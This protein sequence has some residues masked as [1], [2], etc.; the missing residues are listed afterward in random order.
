MLMNNTSDLTSI[1]GI[2]LAGYNVR[3]LISKVDIRVL[4]RKSKIDIL[5]LQE[6][7][8]NDAISS[9]ELHVPDYNIFR[10]DRDHTTCK[11]SGGG[12]LVHTHRRCD[13]EVV[14]HGS[15]S[16]RDIQALW[17][18]LGLKETQPT[19]I[20]NMYRPPSGNVERAI[21]ILDSNIND[22]TNG[23]TTDILLLGD[24]NMDLHTKNSHSN[25]YTQ[26]L[27]ENMLEQMITSP[28]RIPNTKC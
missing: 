28:T 13:I 3:S 21:N 24:T 1:K 7:F 10:Q 27:R 2:S 19:Y 4:L 20:C 6:T 16:N 5:C 23:N 25:I 18:K 17:L 15:T 14:P 8:L 22:L 12:L 26:F 9:T 11:Q